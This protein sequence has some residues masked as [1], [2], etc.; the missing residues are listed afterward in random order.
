MGTVR[1]LLT[2]V[3][4]ANSVGAKQRHFA[5]VCQVRHPFSSMQIFP[6]GSDLIHYLGPDSS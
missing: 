6:G 2:S 5:G 4:E 1:G 3:T